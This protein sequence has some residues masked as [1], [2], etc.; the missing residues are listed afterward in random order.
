MRTRVVAINGTP[1]SGK[2]TVAQ[3]LKKEGRQVINIGEFAKE[4][5]CVIEYDEENQCNVIDEDLIEEK[6]REY[7]SNTDGTV[8]IESHLADLV[9]EELLDR[10]F[11]LEVRVPDL[12]TRLE[13]RGYSTKKIEDNKL[14]ELM[15]DCYM[16][17][18][19]AFGEERVELVAPM[20]I[21]ATVKL[22]EEYLDGLERGR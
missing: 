11:V 4:H 6:L 16:N 21:D 19:D 8:I 22:I 17:S 13:K 3:M 14:S 12:I 15:K 20:E 5:G 18:L 7:L 10:C 2:T 9:P 1:G